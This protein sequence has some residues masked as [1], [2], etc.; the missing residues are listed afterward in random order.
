VVYVRVH[1]RRHFDSLGRVK[2]FAIP[3]GDSNEPS[4]DTAVWTELPSAA[5]FAEVTVPASGFA[6]V[7]VEL[8]PANDPNPTGTN[9][10]YL[11][12]AM[13]RSGDDTDPLPN[14]DRINDADAFWGI[15]SKF[16]DSDNAAARAIPWAP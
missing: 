7:R 10:T 3:L 11:L 4:R 16:S 12:L 14:R 5:A 13:I 8:P 15:V 9:K 2:V 6:Y 1:N